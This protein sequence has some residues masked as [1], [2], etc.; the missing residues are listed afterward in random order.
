MS[1]TIR[2]NKLN[3]KKCREA[4]ETRKQKAKFK[5]GEGDLFEKEPKK[6]N[7]MLVF[8]KEQSRLFRRIAFYENPIFLDVVLNKD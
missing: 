1:K 7:P 4:I 2:K 3:Y 5:R 6:D 8:K